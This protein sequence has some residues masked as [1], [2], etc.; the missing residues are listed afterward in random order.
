MMMMMMMVK[1]RRW[2]RMMIL[3]ALAVVGDGEAKT[4][5]KW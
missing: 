2:K 3:S 1:P 5:R 4:F